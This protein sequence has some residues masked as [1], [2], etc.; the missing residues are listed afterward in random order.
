MEGIGVSFSLNDESG[1][2]HRA[3]D[4]AEHSGAGGSG[5]FAMND[6]L[7]PEVDF[8][9]SEVVMVLD[10]EQDFCA[11]VAGDVSVDELVISSGVMA[12]ELHGCPILLAFVLVEG[13]PSEV[14]EFMWE[15]GAE[16]FSKAA[17]VVANFGACA[18]AATMGKQGEVFAWGKTAD[19]LENFEPA[20]FH[21]VV[22]AAAS[23]EL[24]P[25]FIFETRSD[26]RAIPVF[27]HYWMLPSFFERSAN[28][29]DGFFF[30]CAG[31][32]LL[33]LA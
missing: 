12:H 30:D 26:R 32:P 11:E 6:E 14:G 7:A 13:K 3:W 5:T 4:D 22:S 21:E 20:K 24:G 17:V 8:A 28:A 31:E 16:L 29:E 1:G 33:A 23:A 10:V 27:V 18:T 25:S 19:G 2:G 9:P 15:L